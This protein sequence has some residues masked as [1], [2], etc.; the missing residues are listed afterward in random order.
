MV[1]TSIKD[2]A[3]TWREPIK[4]SA[5]TSGQIIRIN[6]QIP[7]LFVKKQKKL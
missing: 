6:Y 3:V 2:S 4:D 5:A 1:L 7:K